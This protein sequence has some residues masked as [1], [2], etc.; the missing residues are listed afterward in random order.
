MSFPCCWEHLCPAQGKVRTSII[1]LPLD[2]DHS[3]KGDKLPD[4]DRAK[5]E[6]E[7]YTGI[8]NAFTGV[9]LNDHPDLDFPKGKKIMIAGLLIWNH[10]HHCSR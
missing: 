6:T 4:G 8:Y 3:P 1:A 5:V 7:I 9:G 2:K 10:F